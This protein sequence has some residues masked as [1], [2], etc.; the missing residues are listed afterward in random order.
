MG[1]GAQNSDWT[2]QTTWPTTGDPAGRGRRMAVRAEPPLGPVDQLRRLD[3]RGLEQSGWGTER[4]VP[5]DVDGVD[6]GP[7]STAA[8]VDDVD[9]SVRRP[10]RRRACDYDC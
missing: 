2:T 3:E 10:R 7:W 9:R 5:F 4:D 6:H 1:R 8:P